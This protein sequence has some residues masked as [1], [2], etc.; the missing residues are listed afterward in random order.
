MKDVLDMLDAIVKV[1]STVIN[2][3]LDDVLADFR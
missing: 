1:A 2:L 3:Q